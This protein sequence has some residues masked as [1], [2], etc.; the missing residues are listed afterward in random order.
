[1][2][3]PT[4]PSASVIAAA[5]VAILASLFT[6]VAASLG[7]FGILLGSTA[8]VSPELPPFAK[9]MALGTMAFMI[10][11]SIFGIAIGISLIRLRNW[12][13]ISVLTWGGLSVFFGV[14]GGAFALF[15]PIPPQPDVPN[16]PVRFTHLFRLII[17]F[18]YGLPGAV[19]VWWLILFTRRGIT[20]QFAGASSAVSV[21]DLSVPQLQKPRCP[22][23]VLI[24]AWYFIS[25][26]ANVVFLPFLPFH[27]PAV[28]FGHAFQGWIG[29]AILLLNCLLL[30]VAGVG[31]L[32]LKL[33][34]YPFTI[35]L[36]LIQLASGIITIMSPS[37]DSLMKSMISE[38]YSAMH[39]P[40]NVYNPLEVIHN[41]RWFA[42]FG[43]LIPLAI[44]VLLF[45]FRERFL[46]A[47]AAKS[48]APNPS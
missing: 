24:I 2:A 3:N 29:P 21:V 12:A 38:M 47:A 13:R 31:L 4:K 40:T 20:T 22:M 26:A 41:Y 42:Y 5:V 39:L 23:A 45:Y 30:V 37:F 35:A 27:F 25:A 28:Y 19:G 9:N 6:A 46:E 17:L 48:Q 7:F 33:W 1:M 11:L 18:M 15:M 36:Q 43:L 10:C 16:L 32:K 14:F 8:R 34:S 44:V